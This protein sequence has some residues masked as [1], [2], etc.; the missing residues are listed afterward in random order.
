MSEKQELL[1]YR[2]LAAKMART[3]QISEMDALKILKDKIEKLIG[4][5]QNEIEMIG[6]LIAEQEK[7]GE[8][9]TEQKDKDDGRE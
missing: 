8:I 1:P 6:E 2:E 4:H 5:Y 3:N 7:I 9:T